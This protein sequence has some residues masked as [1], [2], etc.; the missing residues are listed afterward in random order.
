[1]RNLDTLIIGA[2]GMQ[3]HSTHFTLERA[4]EAIDEICPQKAFITHVNHNLG[5]SKTSKILPKNVFMAYDG[6][7]LQI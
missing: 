7:K 6:L 3:R 2:L 1:L 4:L 5:Y